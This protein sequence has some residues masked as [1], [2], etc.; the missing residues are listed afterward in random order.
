VA[1]DGTFEY[2]LGQVTPSSIDVQPPSSGND[3]VVFI[4]YTSG[5]DGRQFDIEFRFSNTPATMTYDGENPSK[6]YHLLASAPFG[7]PGISPVVEEYVDVAG[8]PGIIILVLLI[9]AVATYVIVGC[10]VNAFARQ[11]RGIE[12]IPNLEFW[13]DFPFL[14]KD[15]I[16]FTF[17]FPCQKYKERR[18]G[19]ESM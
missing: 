1:T 8:I 16:V 15:G 14:L 4:G 5:N 13:K 18:Q 6:D 17:T 2:G 19:Y 3:W 10:L 11:K 7:I 12:I 9:V